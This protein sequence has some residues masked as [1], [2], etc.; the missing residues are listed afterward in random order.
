MF[1][2]ANKNLVWWP[3]TIDVPV[4]GGKTQPFEIEVLFDL[5]TK[6]AARE[7]ASGEQVAAVVAPRVIDWRNVA[8]DSGTPL[9]CTSA[10]VAAMFELPYVERA[11]VGALVQASSGV[12]V[13]KNS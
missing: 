11:I 6:A 10:N 13:A 1:K 7:A 5:M 12:A 9:P 8:D 4:D 2:L 3:V